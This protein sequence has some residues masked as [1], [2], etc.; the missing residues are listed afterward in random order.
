MPVMIM[1]ATVADGGTLNASTAMSAV[2][3]MLATSSQMRLF[4]LTTLLSTGVM[5]TTPRIM[6]TVMRLEYRLESSRL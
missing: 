2:S 4:S 5:S 6:P 3:T 1:T